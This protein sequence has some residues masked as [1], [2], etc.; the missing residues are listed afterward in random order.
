MNMKLTKTS[1]IFLIVGVLLIAAVSLG[2]TRSQQ[3][4]QQELLKQ[5]LSQAQTKLASFK[6]EDLTAQKDQLTAQVA[7]YNSQLESAKGQLNSNQDSISASGIILET[8]SQTNVQIVSISS[9]GEGTGDVAG[10]PCSILPFNIQVNGDFASVRDFVAL[11]TQKFPTSS[12]QTVQA[13]AV[14]PSTTPTPAQP[15]TIP[16]ASPTSTPAPTASSGVPPSATATTG[17]ATV[18]LVIYSYG[19]K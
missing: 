8:A 9:P 18:A 12:A 6:N 16:T 5:Q 11:L 19:G 2:M 10:T 14:L 3:S 7:Q 4:T 13:Q 15:S 17:S 1:W